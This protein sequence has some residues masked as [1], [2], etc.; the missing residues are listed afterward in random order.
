[1]NMLS[2]KSDLQGFAL[3]FMTA[4]LDFLKCSQTWRPNQKLSFL[5]YVLF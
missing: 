5:V 1:M 2:F 3:G 4:N